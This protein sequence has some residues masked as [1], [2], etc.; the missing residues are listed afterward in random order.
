[1]L[2]PKAMERSAYD[3]DYE[4]LYSIGYR[5]IIFD[6]DN[7]LV[8][9]GA[10]ANARAIE[11]FNRLKALGF[12]ICLLSN[13]KEER[14]KMFNEDVNVFYIYKAG[15]PLRKGYVSAM[16][17]METDTTNTVSIGDQIFTDTVGANNAGINSILVGRIANHEEIQIVLKRFLEFFVLLFYKISGKHKKKFY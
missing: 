8:E 4:K 17:I 10:P 9:H 16:K 15:K 6:I 7:T 11:L 2:F 12:K 14:V 1:M 3:V 13:N 5:G